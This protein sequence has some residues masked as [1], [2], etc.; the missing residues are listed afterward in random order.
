MRE[1]F[2]LDPEVL[3]QH[4]LEDRLTETEADALLTMM[5]AEPALLER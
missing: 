5:Q 3:I 1:G 4:Y 2:S